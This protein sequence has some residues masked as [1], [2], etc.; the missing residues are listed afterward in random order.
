MSGTRSCRRFWIAF[1]VAMAAATLANESSAQTNR[2]A[3]HGDATPSR[4]AKTAHTTATNVANPLQGFSQNRDEP[5]HI[6]AATLE[7]RDKEQK[8]TFT[9]D[10]H[11]VQGDTDLRC[12]KLTVYYEQESGGKTV[13]A[14]TTKVAS[15]QLPNGG[16]QRIRRLEVTGMSS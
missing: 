10:V 8:A 15:P 2:T 16:A 5:I 3:R 7:V 12:D 1:V 14:R 6:D 4:A 11:V 13:G 9:G